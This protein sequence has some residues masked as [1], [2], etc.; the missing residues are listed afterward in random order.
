[1]LDRSKLK[2]FGKHLEIWAK[3]GYLILFIEIPKWTKDWTG[4]F[5]DISFI[6]LP[7][8]NN[9]CRPWGTNSS[10]V[11]LLNDKLRLYNLSNLANWKSISFT[12][13]EFISK[14]LKK[15]IMNSSLHKSA[16]RPSYLM[17]VANSTASVD[18]LAKFAFDASSLLSSYSFFW[19]YFDTLSYFSWKSNLTFLPVC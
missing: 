15:L 4:L 9:S 2:V 6:W 8:K 13:Y 16:V 5:N 19:S 12:P 1:L 18:H 7:F 11:I 10:L 14:W 17:K 3:A